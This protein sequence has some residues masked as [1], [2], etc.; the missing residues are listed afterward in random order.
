ME[1]CPFTYLGTP[2]NYQAFHLNRGFGRT[3][4]RRL[5]CFP[6]ASNFRSPLLIATSQPYG[7]GTTHY[8][9]IVLTTRD[10]AGRYLTSSTSTI[11]RVLGIAHLGQYGSLKLSSCATSESYMLLPSYFTDFHK[12]YSYIK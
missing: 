3:S 1:N 8:C 11:C 10:L 9:H 12:L 6:A 2:P 7:F 4:V 5:N